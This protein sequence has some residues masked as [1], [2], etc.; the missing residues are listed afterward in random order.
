MKFKICTFIDG[1]KNGQLNNTGTL[2]RSFFMKRG[3]VMHT[4]DFVFVFSDLFLDKIKKNRDL[5]HYLSDEADDYKEKNNS[6]L[7]YFENT[8]D[9]QELLFDQIKQ[10]IQN[11]WDQVKVYQCSFD[12]SNHEEYFEFGFLSHDFIITKRSIF[13]IQ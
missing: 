11:D 10:I 2:L 9:S 4:S 13:M 3:I 1:P 12:S 8:S 6:H 7:F 5:Y